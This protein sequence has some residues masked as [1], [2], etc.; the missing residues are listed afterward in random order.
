MK[1]IRTILATAIALTLAAACSSGTDDSGSASDSGAG[2]TVT[3]RY[4]M[5]DE[6]QKPPIEKSLAEFTK[7]HP[8]IKVT[9][10]LNNW[11]D[12]WSKLQT[13]IAGRTAPDVFWDHVAYFPQFSQQGVLTDIGPRVQ[14]DKIDMSIYDP[15]LVEGWQVEGKTYGLPKDWDTIALVY[16]TAALK[17]A[18]LTPADLEGLTWNPDDGGTFVEVLRKLTVDESGK[19][20]GEAGFD[21]KKIKRYGIAMQAPTG[22]QD[23]WNFALQNGCRLQDQPWGK[24]TIDQPACVE[25]IQ[26]VQDLRLKYHVAVPAAV[27]N[28]P[29]GPS[30]DQVVGRGDAATAMD[31]SWMLR[32]Y[33]TALPDGGFGV[34]DLPAGPA[35]K[36]SVYNGLSEAIYAGTEHPEEAWELVKW[37]ASPDSQKIVAEAGS[38]WPGIPSLNDVF[39]QAWQAKGVD[40]TGFKKAAEGTTMGYPLTPSSATYNVKALEIFNQ[41]WLG[42]MSAQDA[43]TKINSESNNAIK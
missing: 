9:I 33:N 10:E 20:P 18:G 28:P 34:A 23:W 31:G 12:Y 35:G 25:A 5:W 4:A 26:F 16:S 1:R 24:W 6:V 27:T 32:A 7:L 30:L 14:A 39:V 13:Q 38:V 19:H 37:L 17:E 42:Q 21:E 40:V 41:V 3:L 8:D 15:K 2:G 22:Q 11:N 36:G 43:A 29:N